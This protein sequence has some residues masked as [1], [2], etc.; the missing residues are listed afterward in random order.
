MS[1][2]LALHFAHKLSSEWSASSVTGQL[3]ETVITYLSSSEKWKALDAQVRTRLVLS[4]LFLRLKELSDLQPSLSTLK[5]T[6]SAD[7]DDWVRCIAAAVGPYDGRLHINEVIHM[8]SMVKH[9]LEEVCRQGKDADPDVYRP[10]EEKFLSKRIVRTLNVLQGI[11]ADARNDGVGG[12]M[13]PSSHSHFVPREEDSLPS[14]P[15]Q[16][17]QQQQQQRT[18]AINPDVSRHGGSQDDS[19]F[20]LRKKPSQRPTAISTANRQG[21]TSMTHAECLP[22]SLSRPPLPPHRLAPSAHGTTASAKAVATGKAQNA[23]AAMQQHVVAPT[24]AAPTIAAP[25]T[26][27]A[28]SKSNDNESSKISAAA[29]FG[30]KKLGTTSAS[31][32]GASKFLGTK[33]KAA[34][35]DL[36]DVTLLNQ[37]AAAAKEKRMKEE[38]VEKERAKAEAKAT[39]LA[40]KEAAKTAR[41]SEAEA[42]KAEMKQAK[43]LAKKAG[44][45]LNSGGRKKIK[46]ESKNGDEDDAKE[47]GRREAENDEEEKGED[48]MPMPLTKKTGKRATDF[49][50]TVDKSNAQNAVDATATEAESNQLFDRPFKIQKTKKVSDE[51][52]PALLDP[53]IAARAL[54]QA[55]MLA[56]AHALDGESD[57]PVYLQYMQFAKEDSDYDDI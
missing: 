5:T 44:L 37:Q 57:N 38:V 34:I 13:L 41:R 40:E 14:S 29:G 8:N 48:G 56:G 4:P 33:K 2:D 52:Q 26:A 6:A 21:I 51:H 32:F 17:Q 45:S 30:I 7:K 43:E 16:Q 10:L 18:T 11:N 27:A 3:S 47:I 31:K 22:T 39:K 50:A 9:T 1:R 55:S 36:K 23:G 12:P 20:F 19:A 15:S 35:L 42:R 25:T 24:T 53:A 54:E 46:K 49:D 28:A